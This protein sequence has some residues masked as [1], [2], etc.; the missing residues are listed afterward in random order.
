M[1]PTARRS[2][3]K[4]RDYATIAERIL[5]L[6][7]ARAEKNGEHAASEPPLPHRCFCGQASGALAEVIEVCLD[8]YDNTRV[9]S[10]AWNWMLPSIG[11]GLDSRLVWARV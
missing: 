10:H 2:C 9:M 3:L 11:W 1:K 6:Y 8:S 7:G 5:N 4:P